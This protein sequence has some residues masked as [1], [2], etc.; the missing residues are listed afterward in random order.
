MSIVKQMYRCHICT[1]YLKGC[2]KPEIFLHV[3]PIRP[4]KKAFK[5]SVMSPV[6]GTDLK[7]DAVVWLQYINP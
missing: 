4:M 5:F 6:A 1:T 3:K 2:V 7:N